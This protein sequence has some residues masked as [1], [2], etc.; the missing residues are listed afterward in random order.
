M[1]ALF[2]NILVTVSVTDDV[3]TVVYIQQGMSYLV[4]TNI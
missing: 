2:G 1:F 3:P 4:K